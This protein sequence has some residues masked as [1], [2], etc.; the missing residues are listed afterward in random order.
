[1]KTVTWEIFF[2]S[3]VFFRE[4]DVETGNSGVLNI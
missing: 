3:S 2:I 4:I 1:M